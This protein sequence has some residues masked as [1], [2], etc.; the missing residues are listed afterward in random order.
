[1]ADPYTK[2][3]V[4]RGVLKVGYRDNKSGATK[5][6]VDLPGNSAAWRLGSRLGDGAVTMK[7]QTPWKE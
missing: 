2:S 6:V 7:S 4:E 1:M 5:Y 3:L